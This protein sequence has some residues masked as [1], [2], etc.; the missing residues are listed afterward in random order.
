MLILFGHLTGPHWSPTM[1]QER[2]GSSLI[3][4]DMRPWYSMETIIPR[5]NMLPKSSLYLILIGVEFVWKICSWFSYRLAMPLRW[6]V[7]HTIIMSN[8]NRYRYLNWDSR[9]GE[10]IRSKTA[11]RPWDWELFCHSFKPIRLRD[12]DLHGGYDTVKGFEKDPSAKP[13]CGT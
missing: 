12:V 6:T 13:G 9:G 1:L 5:A 3:L 7:Y 2:V 4:R 8:W 11:Q 10:H